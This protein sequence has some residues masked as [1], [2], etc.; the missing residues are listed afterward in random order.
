MSRMRGEKGVAVSD[1]DGE[2]ECCCASAALYRESRS[3]YCM[4][5]TAAGAEETAEAAEADSVRVVVV[6]EATGVDNSMAVA[7]EVE[8]VAGAGAET[9][10]PSGGLWAGSG[11]GEGEVADSSTEEGEEAVEAIEGDGD[12]DVFEE[13]DDADDDAAT[14]VEATGAATG[15]VGRLGHSNFDPCCLIQSSARLAAC[16]ELSGVKE[17]L[18]AQ[19]SV[20]QSRVV[21]PAVNCRTYAWNTWR[22]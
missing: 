21:Q 2:V 7:V 5:D 6:G 14:A 19:L 12:D 3:E 10:L 22:M 18:E 8:D 15:N 11:E 17:G 16:C 1:G 20:G 9:E 13:E 4:D